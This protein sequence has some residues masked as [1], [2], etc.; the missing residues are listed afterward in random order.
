[1]PASS[2]SGTPITMNPN[3]S[4]ARVLVAVLLVLGVLDLSQ[5]R[6]VGGFRYVPRQGA[7]GVGG[8]VK[9]YRVYVGDGLVR[10]GTN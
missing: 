9:D 3:R 1:M 4:L 10:P 8:R 7:V 5:S 2:F 6:T